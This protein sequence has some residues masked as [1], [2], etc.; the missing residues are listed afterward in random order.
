MNDFITV[1]KKKKKVFL[2]V[3]VYRITLYYSS[4]HV[5]VNPLSHSYTR[6]ILITINCFAKVVSPM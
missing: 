2:K 3:N 5:D 1:R 6:M 4:I